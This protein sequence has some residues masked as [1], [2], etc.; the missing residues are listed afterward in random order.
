MTEGGIPKCA[1]SFSA[2]LRSGQTPSHTLPSPSAV[3]PSS[4]FSIAAA[5]SCTQKS[6]PAAGIPRFMLPQTM[7]AAGAANLPNGSIARSAA[8]SPGSSTSTISQGQRFIA[9]GAAI[10]SRASSVSFSGST[11]RSS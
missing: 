8:S 6:R 2:T 3:A 10:A 5:Q 4:R 1:L 9:E 7:T 11:G